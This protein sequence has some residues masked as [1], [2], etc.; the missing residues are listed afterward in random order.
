MP[1]QLQTLLGALAVVG[2]AL[3]QFPTTT[4]E[5]SVTMAT[6]PNSPQAT[7]TGL[8]RLVAQLPSC[9]IPCFESAAKTINCT[10]TDFSCLCRAGSAQSLALNV[11]TCIGGPAL[12]GGGGGIGNNGTSN[13]DDDDDANDGCELDDL[14]ELSRLAG[15]ICAAVAAT[16]NQSELAAATSIVSQ[17]IAQAS[18]TGTAGGSGSGRQNNAGRAGQAS[19]GMLAI[20]AAY[21]VFFL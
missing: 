7:A 2:P 21:A 10:P 15:Q 20:V 19:M 16:P 9:A 8:P 11:G 17:A 5:P 3:A 1:A 12:F 14:D 6:A 18:A 13:S 4:L